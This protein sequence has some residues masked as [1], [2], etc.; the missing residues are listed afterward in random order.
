[1]E[2]YSLEELTEVIRRSSTLLELDLTEEALVE[3]ASRSRGTPRIANRLLRRVRDFRQVNPSVSALEATRQALTIYDV[4]SRGL[5][6]LDRAYLETLGKRFSGGPVGLSSLAVSIGEDIETIETVV[7]PFL[8]REGLI[9]RSSRGRVITTDG[10]QH[11]G[12]TPT[13]PAK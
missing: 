4:D 9:T 2:F 3:L 7:E 11:L 8:I 1:L 6:R 12:I 13:E 10:W 5:D